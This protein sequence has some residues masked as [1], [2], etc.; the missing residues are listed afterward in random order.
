M[1]D[2][3]ERHSPVP[4]YEQLV[5]ILREQILDGR[6]AADERLPSELELCRAF[7]LSRATVRQT[8]QMLERQGLAR[9][10]PGRGVFAT[11]PRDASGWTVQD[12]QGFLE[13]QVRQG[14]NG[15]TTEVLDATVVPADQHVRVA[16]GL[17]DGDTVFALTRVRTRDGDKAMYSTN[18]FPEP[19]SGVIRT[20]ATVLDGTGSVNSA[21]RAAGY[22]PHRAHRVMEA[23]PA[24][25]AVARHL[26]VASRTPVLRVR[27]SSW[28]QSGACFDYYETWVLTDVVPLEVEVAT[29]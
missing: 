11:D 6:L 26:G 25:E 7:G 28:D 24:P 17:Q 10:V 20:D 8:M 22:V 27:S 4:Y 9:R 15:V 16:L 2:T 12:N 14:R 18:W 13:L 19:V 1:S 29:G 21:L 23:L 3:I 5:S